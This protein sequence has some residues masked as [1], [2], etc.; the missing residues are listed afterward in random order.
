[1]QVI[2]EVEGEDEEE[3]EVVCWGG[4]RGWGGVF[5]GV[6][7]RRGEGEDTSGEWGVDD[8]EDGAR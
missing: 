4:A 3:G 2:E 1:M 7:V 6:G 8:I 5:F